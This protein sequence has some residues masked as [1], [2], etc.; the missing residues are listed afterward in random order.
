MITRI[1]IFLSLGAVLLSVFMPMESQADTLNKPHLN[2]QTS[3]EIDVM[4]DFIKL[5]ITIEHQAPT[6][7]AAKKHV[8]A[9]AE[10]VLTLS[11]K[12]NIPA[13]HIDN[14]NIQIRPEYQWKDKTRH[15]LGQKVS[16][17]IN[18]KLY[19]LEDYGDFIQQLSKINITRFHAQGFGFDDMSALQTQA[20]LKALDK[21]QVK[22]QAI[23]DNTGRKLGAIFQ[24]SEIASPQ[25][26]PVARS[27]QM[28]SAKTPENNHID[29]KPQ[30]IKAKVNVI[31]LLK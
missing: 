2:L 23:A 6:A 10:K 19:Q 29:I 24:V 18:I 3:A 8:D 22:A 30:S 20:L 9:I 21:S 13:K 14:A 16:L 11:N 25:H 17:Q 28:N 15:L 1:L 27:L 26:Y 5:N 12:L 4:P 7:D 31:Y